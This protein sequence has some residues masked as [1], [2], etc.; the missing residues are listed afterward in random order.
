MSTSALSRPGERERP[1]FKFLEIDWV[2][3]LLLCMIAGAGGLIMFSV[4]GGHWGPWAAAHLVRFGFFFVLMIIL[5]MVDLR[6]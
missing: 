3:C 1:L 6:V 2:F 5:S 4:A